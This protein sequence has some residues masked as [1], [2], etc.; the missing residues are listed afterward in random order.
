MFC[1]RINSIEYR[2][3]RVSC[4]SRIGV[5]V[6]SLSTLRPAT[7]KIILRR[8]PPILTPFQAAG[9]VHLSTCPCAREPSHVSPFSCLSYSFPF[10]LFNIFY[11]FLPPPPSTKALKSIIYFWGGGGGR[12]TW[13]HGT[14]GMCV[15]VCGGVKTGILG[16]GTCVCFSGVAFRL[17]KFQKSLN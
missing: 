10:Q 12:D 15:C 8:T 13:F 6:S 4:S 16:V 14:R 5:F 1:A 7:W 11:L 2:V 9:A 3:S 17:G